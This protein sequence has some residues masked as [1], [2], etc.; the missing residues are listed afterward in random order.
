MIHVLRRVTFQRVITIDFPL[1][2]QFILDQYLCMS[3]IT[4]HSQYH[5]ITL[6]SFTALYHFMF[7]TQYL[8]YMYIYK[9]IFVYLFVYVSLTSFMIMTD[10]RLMG[11][12]LISLYSDVVQGTA[13]CF[14]LRGIFLFAI[15]ICTSM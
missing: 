1:I 14:I 6:S 9:S 12:L 8:F 10:S 13:G 7:S 11:Y 15:L 5:L 3:H 2:F 4:L